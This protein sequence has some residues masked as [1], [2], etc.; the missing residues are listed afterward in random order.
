MKY[1]ER[2]EGYLVHKNMNPKQCLVN[3][4][5][6]SAIVQKKC[7]TATDEDYGQASGNSDKF[8]VQFRH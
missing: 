1:T 7:K 6:E 2:S 4:W 5:T 8:G 3:F